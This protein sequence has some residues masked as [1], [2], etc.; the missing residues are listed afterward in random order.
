MDES[1]STITDALSVLIG[2]V[3]LSAGEDGDEWSRRVDDD[4]ESDDGDGDD[5]SACNRFVFVVRQRLRM[6][7]LQVISADSMSINMKRAADGATSSGHRARMKLI[8]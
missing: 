8:N 4:D 5:E 6:E 2:A 3:L 1:R 7:L